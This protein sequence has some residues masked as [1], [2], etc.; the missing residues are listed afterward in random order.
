MNMTTIDAFKEIHHREFKGTWELQ[1]VGE[2]KL[3]RDDVTSGKLRL[4]LQE[5][6]SLMVLFS[7]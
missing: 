1:S 6:F 2:T 7:F 3:P 4:V 5:E